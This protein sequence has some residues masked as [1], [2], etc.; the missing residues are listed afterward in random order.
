MSEMRAEQR[1]RVRALRS[2]WRDRPAARNVANQCYRTWPTD[3]AAAPSSARQML[4][5]REYTRAFAGPH[6]KP[7]AVG[8]NRRCCDTCRSW[9]TA[10]HVVHLFFFVAFLEGTAYP[11]YESKPVRS[12]DGRFARCF[13]NHSTA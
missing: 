5:R 6:R 8:L 10:S 7:Y 13:R 3:V 11:W 12:K 9:L 2:S 4:V 1:R